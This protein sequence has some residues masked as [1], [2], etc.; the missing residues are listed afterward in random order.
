[1][2]KLGG[3]SNAMIPSYD[4]AT[5]LDLGQVFAEALRTEGTKLG[6][7][8]MLP[9]EAKTP[10][11]TINDDHSERSTAFG[12][13]RRAALERERGGEERD[14]GED[15]GGAEERRGGDA[16]VAGHAASGACDD[17][18]AGD[19]GGGSDRDD[20]CCAREELAGQRV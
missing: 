18:R 15:G 13:M 16:E 20:E 19:S 8:M 17:D 7:T 9:Q 6:L 5:T 12:S 3:V 10:Q 4:L 14:G 11:W 1:M 2:A